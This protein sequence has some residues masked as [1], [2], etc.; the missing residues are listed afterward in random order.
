ME[1]TVTMSIFLMLLTAMVTSFSTIQRTNIRQEKRNQVNGEMRL[2][3]ERLT[4]EA[5]QATKIYSTSNAT[6]LDMD[7]YLDGTLTRVVYTATGT[8]FT[9]GTPSGGTRTILE[10]LTSTTIFTYTPTVEGATDIA[11]DLRARPVRFSTDPAVVRLTSEVR[12][13]NVRPA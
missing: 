11:I 9:R 6:K 8:T 12:L 4:K 10:G 3:M 2:V 13:R 5:R 7:T 1:M